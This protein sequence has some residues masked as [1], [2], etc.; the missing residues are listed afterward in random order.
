MPD[1]LT[2][3]LTVDDFAASLRLGTEA[4]GTPP[5]G[6]PT[7]SA[8]EFPYPGRHSWGTFEGDRLVARMV[9]RQYHAWFHGRAVPTCGVAGVTVEAEHRG[10]GLLADLMAATLT[11][12]GERGEVLSTL[13][14]SAPGIYRPFGYELVGSCD[15][16]EVPVGE[17]ATV[18]PPASTITT[19]RA[20][21]ADVDAVRGV[22][23][24]WA[25]A[26][27]GPLTRSGASFPATADEL[28]GGFTGVTLA[29]DEA[30]TVVGYCSWNRGTG[31]DADAGVE[32]SDLLA[33]TSD[34]YRVLWRMLGSFTSVTGQVRVR[35]SGDDVAR[36]V[37]PSASWRVRRRYPY[38]LRV[39][40]VA[41]ALSGIE[42][43]LDADLRFSVT[44]DRLGTA[45]GAYRL[46]TIDGRTTCGTAPEA[47]TATATATDMLAPVLDVRGLALAY[48]GVQSCANLRLAGLLTGPD[49]HDATLDALLGGR[50][51]HIR[52][53]F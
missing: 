8:A 31:Y 12:A 49:A 34:G 51:L 37:L 13:F 35:T 40:A 21:A 23:D 29:V 42:T 10:E 22:Y 33:L 2:R 14:P 25:A 11:E 17:L 52:D 26:Q 19:R 32:V 39:H 41:P 5:P 46:R 28:V 6:T 24:S 36:L 20:T 44:G 47:A 48:A 4:F 7:P 38:M 1:R 16:I 3:L 43:P 27:N 53:Y 30:G 50:Q 45:N 15:E 18:R 9:G